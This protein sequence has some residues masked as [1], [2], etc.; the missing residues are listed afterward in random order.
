MLLW[1]QRPLPRKDR[2]VDAHP[3]TFLLRRALSARQTRLAR[4]EIRMP[5]PRA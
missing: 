1:L 2:R 4:V 5:R 3:F